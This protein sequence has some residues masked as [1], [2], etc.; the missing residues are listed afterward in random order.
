MMHSLDL[1]GALPVWVWVALGVWLLFSL[2][3]RNYRRPR[4]RVFKRRA[5]S[6][7]SRASRVRNLHRRKARLSAAHPTFAA[8]QA[9]S[10]AG[11]VGGAQY[12]NVTDVGLLAYRHPE[13]DP[14]VVRGQGVLLDTRFLRPF[15]TLWLPRAA[16]GYVRFEILDAEGRLRYADEARYSLR[17]GENPLL[18]NAWLP[19]E[20]KGRVSDRWTLR[21]LASDM[22]LAEH[23]FGWREVGASA[24]QPYLAADGEISP[25]LWQMA[26]E[27][28]AQQVSLT[29]LLA[30]QEE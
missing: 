1:L 28:A 23:V 20:G 11:Y 24:L 8:Q 6:L 13:A 16:R 3:R 19:V 27:E 4:R 29:E 5:D 17:R 10:R 21:V 12:A 25:E 2:N 15:V 22:L 18:P 26:Q 7:P 14:R 30:E 9:M